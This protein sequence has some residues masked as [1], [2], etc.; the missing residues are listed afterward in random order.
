MKREI[1]IGTRWMGAV[2]LLALGG[3]GDDKKPASDAAPSTPQTMVNSIGAD[4]KV[5]VTIVDNAPTK[6]DSTGKTVA[7]CPSTAPYGLC[8][9]GKL[10][11]TNSGTTD[12]AGGFTIYYSSIR[13]VLSADTNQFT[14]THVNGDLHKIETTAAF[15]GWKAGDTKEIPFKAEYW[16]ISETD[17]MPRFYVTAE[18]ADP[19]L[20]KST[21]VADV[22]DLVTPL[23]D[24]AIMKRTPDDKSVF[25]TAAT[26]FSVNGEITDLGAAAVATEVV[27]TPTAITAGTGTLDLSSGI[28]LHADAI[29]ADAIAAALAHFKAIGVNSV[30]AGVAVT[31]TVDAQDPAFAGKT[32]AEAYRLAVAADAVTIVGGDASGAFYG[33]QTLAGL[34]PASG[35][36]IPLTTVAYDSPRYAYRGVQIDLARNFHSSAEIL[37]VID[38]AAAYKLNNLHLHLSDDEGWR[39][40][41]PGLPELTAVAS[42]RCHDLSEKTC[43][44]PQLGSGPTATTTGTGHLST[45]EFVEILRAAKAHFIT[46]VPEFDM[47]G[48]VRAAIKA[49]EVHSAAGDKTYLLS[50]PMDKSSYLSTQYY[51]DN[52]LNPCMDSTYAFIGTVM[53]EVAKMYTMA[54][55]SLTTWHVGGDEVGAGAWAASPACAALYATGGEV[56]TV[57]DVH[58]H[59]IRK[60]NALAKAHG[61]GIRGWSDGLRKTVPDT[62]GAPTKVFLDIQSDLAGNAA[63]VNWWGTLFWWDNSAYQLANAG[64]KVILTSPDFLYLDHPYEADPKERGYYWAT[65]YTDVRKLFS[66]VSGNLPANSQ[67]SVD[68]Q[69]FDY[70]YAFVPTATVPTPVIPLTAPANIV[71]LEGA[72][73]SE[74]VRTDDNVD[75]MVFPRLLA[76]AERA[77]HRADWEPADGILYSAPVDKAKLAIDWQRFANVL[78]HKELAKL[79]KAQVAYRVEVPGAKIVGGTLSANV[80]MPGLVI[81]YQKAD[82]TWAAYDAAHPPT[83]TTTQVRAL[84]ASGRAGRA[85]SVP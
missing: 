37:K 25:A 24:L 64:Y 36:K 33:L 13:K 35:G 30:A 29:G 23:A 2:M 20:I 53:N 11:L 41:I 7:D 45:A 65:R 3:C 57:D 1:V 40:E 82:G 46:V 56:K 54:G 61:L 27:P 5:K 49:M 60:V 32:T 81:Q 79:D 38:Q 44:L 22:A 78:G 21:D 69:G 58:G 62:S 80:G 26:R 76:L 28:A 72:L 84:T 48:H 51:T 75:Y 31:V 8:F 77:W 68:R 55:A 71:G 67:I 18:G 70:T 9:S 83:V 17:V 39:L 66:Y 43:I 85:V 52:A 14:I 63:S 73:F 16:L 47:P 15:T 34:V 10:V 4:L 42:Q 50:D 12:W 19:A 6:V 74:T 59:F